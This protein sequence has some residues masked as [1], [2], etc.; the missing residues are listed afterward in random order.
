[1]VNSFELISVSSLCIILHRIA[2]TLIRQ[3]QTCLNRRFHT[4]FGKLREIVKKF[5]VNWVNSAHRKSYWLFGK[6]FFILKVFDCMLNSLPIKSCSNLAM[7]KS[8]ANSI[9][10][11]KHGAQEPSVHPQKTHQLI[12]DL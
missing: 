8:N 5:R 6:R 4:S 2:T 10:R 12:N 11:G 1:M 3:V 9:A 7:R